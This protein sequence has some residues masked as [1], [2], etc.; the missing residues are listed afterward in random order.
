METETYSISFFGLDLHYYSRTVVGGLWKAAA[1]NVYQK[2]GII[3]VGE[4]NVRYFVE[5]SNEVLS[6]Q[7]II[8]I[9][10]VRIPHRSGTEFEY[11]DAYKDVLK[12]VREN[13]GNPRT[14]LLTEKATLTV[15]E[16]L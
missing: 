8:V 2:T 6:G 5:P 16:Q 12:E 13:L 9:T 15:V 14:G 1:Q 3:I 10:S 11:W 7:D 4:V